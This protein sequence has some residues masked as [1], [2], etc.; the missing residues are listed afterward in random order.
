MKSN[1]YFKPTALTNLQTSFPIVRSMFVGVVLEEGTEYIHTGIAQSVVPESAWDRGLHIMY[2]LSG[3]LPSLEV[4]TVT[5]YAHGEEMNASVIDP[6]VGHLYLKELSG[7]NTDH[8]S[9]AE[10]KD[11]LYVFRI[12]EIASNFHFEIWIF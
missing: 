7:I 2:K 11:L 4:R 12:L 5:R 6:Y 10:K 9:R 1:I 8:L 3:K